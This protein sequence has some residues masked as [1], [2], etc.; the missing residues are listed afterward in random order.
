MLINDRTGMLSA[1]DIQTMRLVYSFY[2]LA[3]VIID[4]YFPLDPEM[5]E[6]MVE[7]FSDKAGYSVKQKKPLLGRGLYKEG[8]ELRRIRTI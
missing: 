8:A 7:Y 1:V 5:I 4:N 3:S 6:E 2:D